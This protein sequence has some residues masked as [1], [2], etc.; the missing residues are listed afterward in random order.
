MFTIGGYKRIVGFVEIIQQPLMHGQSGAKYGAQYGLT[1]QHPMCSRAQWGGYF[2]L[3]GRQLLADLKS[4][5]FSDPL[6]V[7][8]ETHSV[9]L[10]IDIPQLGDPITDERM[11]LTE[12]DDHDGYTN[13]DKSN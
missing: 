6:E 2:H 1:F 5:R 10:H 3:F 8:P 7:S 12:V 11:L 9:R 4:D 13:F